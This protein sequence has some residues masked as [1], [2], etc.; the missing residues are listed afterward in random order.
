M[1]EFNGYMPYKK[2]H[3]NTLK[4]SGNFTQKMEE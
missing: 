2:T 4:K 1:L 3:K